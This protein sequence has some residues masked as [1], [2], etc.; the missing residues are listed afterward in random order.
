MSASASVITIDG[1]AGS[2]KGTV[3][4]RLCQELLWHYLDS[5]AIYRLLAL[6]SLQK[7]VT[8]DDISG[9]V[10]LAKGMQV[11][12]KL[13]ADGSDTVCL[14]GQDVT[15]RIRDEST[16]ARASEVASIPPVREALLEWQRQRCQPPG[17]VAEGRDMGT[18]VFPQAALKIY[19]TASPEER[20]SRRH[21]QLK[22]KGFDVSLA[23]VFEDMVARDTRDINR[24][25]APLKP[26]P[27]AVILESDGLSVDQVVEAILQLASTR[28]C[29]TVL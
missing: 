11:V 26:A 8:P 25:N 18:V 28:F 19:L 5:G 21:K 20:A 9:L 23:R 15:E 3:A 29:T 24:D 13:N 16:G 7:E 22:E 17:L 10:S 6:N 2:G 12:F 27:D 1:P 14:N 4:K